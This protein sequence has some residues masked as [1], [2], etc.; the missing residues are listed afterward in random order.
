MSILAINPVGLSLNAF[1]NDFTQRLRKFNEAVHDAVRNSTSQLD[2]KMLK[3]KTRTEKKENEAKA[4]AR[5]VLA[6]RKTQ[7]KLLAMRNYSDAWDQMKEIRRAEKDAVAAYRAQARPEME[8]E[9]NAVQEERLPAVERIRD[10]AQRRVRSYQHLFPWTH[11][12]HETYQPRNCETWITWPASLVESQL[13]C[14][15][16]YVLAMTR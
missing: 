5:P 4:V 13:L 7:Q 15:F 2:A 6:L 14:H 12:R 16:F 8:A 9:L 10:S 11:T 1:D 3:V